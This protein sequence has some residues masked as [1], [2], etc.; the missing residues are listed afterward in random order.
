[1]LEIMFLLSL[2]IVLVVPA[3][4]KFAYT[5]EG[6]IGSFFFLFKYLKI[7]YFIG[8][9]QWAD[10]FHTFS[11]VPFF[12]L[13]IIISAIYHDTWL[14]NLVTPWAMLMQFAWFINN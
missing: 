13:F 3:I 6:N 1:M 2:H 11:F 5:V 4:L 8:D 9:P 10:S 14:L 12:S 7:S